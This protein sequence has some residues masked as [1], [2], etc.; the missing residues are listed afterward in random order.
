MK[1]EMLL[2]KYIAEIR[3]GQ[4]ASSIKSVKTITSLSSTDEEAWRQVRRELQVIGISP[5][6][7]DQNR[8]MIIMKLQEALGEAANE[9]TTKPTHV[10]KA[11]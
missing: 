5:S 11:S 7:F 9:L 2:Q 1:L 8:E 10:K 3:D 4:R 6:Q